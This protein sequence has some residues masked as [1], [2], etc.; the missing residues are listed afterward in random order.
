[1][2]RRSSKVDGVVREGMD[3]IRSF[4][5]TLKRPLAAQGYFHRSTVLVKEA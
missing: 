5:T 4:T 3:F 1:M 2:N